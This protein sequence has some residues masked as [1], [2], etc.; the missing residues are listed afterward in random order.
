[1][2]A[3]NPFYNKLILITGG[4]S[5][6][7]FALAKKLVPLGAHVYLL[8][9]NENNLQEAVAQLETARQF[10]EQKIGW[11][12]ADVA[13]AE[14]IQAVLH[15]FQQQQGTPDFLFNCA[16]V[17]HPGRFEELDLAKFRWMIDVNYL[18]MVSVIHA[19]LPAMLARKS[20]HIINIG[21]AASFL[22]IYGYTAY[23]GSKFALRGM[24]DALR[25]EVKPYHIA[26]SIVY[27]PDTD[28]PQLAYEEQYKPAITKEISGT[29]KPLSAGHVAEKILAGVV[30]R[31]YVIIPDIQTSLFYR[32]TS[33]LGDFTY[34]VMDWMVNDAIRKHGL[35]KI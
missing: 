16:G 13:E 22:A 31:K 9:R 12:K 15:D 23:S 19:L 21:S 20:G 24:S 29:I 11:I 26:L 6:I 18:G 35:P 33:L 7:G 14:K 3:T 2:S 8:A 27:P 30:R 17:V 1:M 32:L 34:R 10:Q 25:S 5:G 28:T 4:S